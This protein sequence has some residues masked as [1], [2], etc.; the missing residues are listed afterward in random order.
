AAASERAGQEVRRKRAS[1]AL[2]FIADEMQRLCRYVLQLAPANESF[3]TPM[4]NPNF[5]GGDFR[6]GRRQL[7][8]VAMVGNDE[9][10]FDALLFGALSD[11]HPARGKGWDWIGKPSRPAVGESRGRAD[12]D[13]SCKIRLCRTAFQG[14][15]FERAEIDTLRLII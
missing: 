3:L 7:I 14:G 15:R 9:R 1:V 12:D 4:G 11:A 5:C 13:L 6:Y 8:P 10:Q 2:I